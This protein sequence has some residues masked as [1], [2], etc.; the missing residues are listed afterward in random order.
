MKAIA[1]FM[2]VFIA[3][4]ASGCAIFRHQVSGSGAIEERSICIPAASTN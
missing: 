2:L 1:K 4:F 3:I